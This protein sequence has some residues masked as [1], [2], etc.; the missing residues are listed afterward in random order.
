M[1]DYFDDNPM[2]KAEKDRLEARVVAAHNTCH[3]WLIEH[4]QA[5]VCPAHLAGALA[6]AELALRLHRQ[7]ESDR[8]FETERV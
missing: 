2:W 8:Y 5:R 1:A 4:P 3:D 7:K 6:E